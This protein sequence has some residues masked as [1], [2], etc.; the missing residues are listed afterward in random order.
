MNNA[1]FFQTQQIP[2][3][4]TLLNQFKKEYTLKT[5][6][7]SYLTQNNRRVRDSTY[8][9]K[10]MESKSFSEDSKSLLKT[11]EQSEEYIIYTLQSR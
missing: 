4:T 2:D 6:M 8:R 3:D 11:S 9:E 5:N 1:F 10:E 7:G